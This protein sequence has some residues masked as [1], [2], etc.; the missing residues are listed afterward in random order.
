MVHQNK[1]MWIKIELVM[2]MNP[3]IEKKLR[4]IKLA[5]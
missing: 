2:I 3:R 4:G 1:E 5:P